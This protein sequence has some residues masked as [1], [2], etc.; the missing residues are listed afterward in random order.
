MKLKI[1]IFLLLICLLTVAPASAWTITGEDPDENLDSVNTGTASWITSPSTGSYIKYSWTTASTNIIINKPFSPNSISFSAKRGTSSLGYGCT[2]SIIGENGS[3]LCSFSLPSLSTNYNRYEFVSGLPGY[4]DI[5]VNGVFINTHPISDGEATALKFYLSNTGGTYSKEFYLDDIS[6]DHYVFGCNDEVSLSDDSFFFSYGYPKS[7][8][9]NFYVRLV[10]PNNEF[11]EWDTSSAS[12]GSYY[13]DRGDY[14]TEPGT[15]SLRLYMEDLLTGYDYL[16]YTKSLIYTVPDPASI[17]LLSSE[18]EAGEQLKVICYN[19]QGYTLQVVPLGGSLTAY[20]I[21]S[22]EKTVAH[23]IP[24]STPVG[25]GTV[26][27]RNPSGGIVDY[28]YFDVYGGVSAD[29]S[30]NLDKNAYVNTDAVKISYNDLPSG[31]TILFRGSDGDEYLID[32]SWTKSGS[33]ILSYE[34]GGESLKSVMVYAVYSGT[35][36]DSD[37]A[38]VA[39]G[40][41]YAI[42]GTVYDANTLAPISG[43]TVN[44]AGQVKYTDE[45]GRYDMTVSAGTQSISSTADGYNTYS[46]TINIIS[47][48]TQ[49]NIYLVPVTP[50]EE[51]F[52]A[53]YG[54]C[55]DYETG[56]AIETAYIQI[57]NSSGVTYS[58]LGRSSTGSY[59]FEGIPNGSTWTLKASKTGYDNYQKEITVNGSTFHLIRLVSQD[60]SSTSGDYEDGDST[61]TTTER[62]GREAAKN[63]MKEFEALVP[64]LISLVGIKVFK[65]L[66]K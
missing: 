13:L 34:L 24:L 51:G 62:P 5:Y 9:C 39:Y 26:I 42:Y 35:I 23:A 48:S 41:N 11:Y 20:S 22:L 64:G 18:I 36:L 65:E 19:A 52:G 53:I 60:S 61:E 21:N 33:G 12:V 16:L 54:A 2:A 66:M 17:H 40:D 37:T 6:T 38:T 49:K 4:L 59:I 56:A 7:T 44:I 28:E 8:D 1:G 32:K 15:Y 27:L 55:A 31:T 43:A 47:V 10:E 29:A 30:I 46:S 58:A 45:V 25:R 14:F 63:A 57:S 50:S 3:T